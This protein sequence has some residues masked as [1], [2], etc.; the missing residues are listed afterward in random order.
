MC[1]LF[2]LLD[3]GHS[4]SAGEKS[5]MLAVLG[6]VSEARGT[7]AT[8]YSYV[9][10]RNLIIKKKAVPAHEMRFDI[11][12][13][14]YVIMGHTRLTTQGNAARQKNNHPFPGKAAKLQFALAHN[15]VISNDKALRKSENLPRT[16]IA[17]DSYVAVQ[18]IE[19][20]NALDFDSLKA[21]AEKVKGTFTFTVMDIKNTLYIVKGN[22]PLSLYYFPEKS[23]YIYA[24]T[25]AILET[26]LDAMGWLDRYHEEIPIAEGEILKIDAAGTVTRASFQPP[27]AKYVYDPICDD[28]WDY[29]E[30][31]LDEATGYRKILMDFGRAMGVSQKELDHLHTMGLS[32]LEM[33]ECIYN[34]RFRRML[35]LETGYYYDELEGTFDDCFEDLAGPTA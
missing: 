11:P 5:R 2:G 9:S 33:E 8:G 16:K 17:T 15:G 30:P 12:E 13:N 35:L 26:A 6:N 25:R 32:D 1:C 10:H 29:W 18:L 14:A 22:N 27:A 3:M 24:S 31:P 20:Q 28:F 23:V 21:M 34:S 4:L 7:D 19:K